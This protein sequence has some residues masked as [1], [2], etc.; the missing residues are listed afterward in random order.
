MLLLTLSVFS[1]PTIFNGIVPPANAVSA[2]FSFAASGD[3]GSLTVSSSVN[4]LNRLMTASPNFFLGLG[5]FSYDPSVTGNTWCG[6]FKSSFNGIQILPGDHDTGGHNSATF[7]E[8]HSYERYVN[9]CP[10]TLGVPLVCG[11]VSGACYGK[12]YYFDYP[13]A[14]P[15]AR[16]IFASPKIYN[17]TGVCTSSPNC[18]SQTGQPCTDQYGCWQYN[19]NDIHYNWTAS[20]IDD[21]RARGIGWVIVATH[22]LCISSADATC[23]TGIA[24]FNMLVQKKVDLIIQAHDNAYERSKQLA[25]NSG[26]CPKIATDGSGY[27]VYNSGCVVDSGL[28]NYTRGLGSVVVV[29]GAWENDLYGVNASASTP[30]NAAEAPFFAEL[31]GKN[32]PGNG[33]GFTKYTA[34]ASRID[35]QTSFSGG[36]SDSF[37]ITNG[38]APIPLS[39]WPAL[40]ANPGT[41]EKEFKFAW[42]RATF[43]AKGLYWAFWVNVGTCEGQSRCLYYSS[44]VDGVTWAAPTN[45]GIHGNRED[46]SVT[47]DGTNVYYARYNETDYFSSTCSRALLFRQ[48]AISGG[49]VNWQ[50]ENVVLPAN[51]TTAF[52]SPNLKIDSNGQAWIGYLYS[53]T[54]TCG[55][56]GTEQPRAIHSKGTNYGSWSSQ[57]V[58]SNAQNGNWAVD[59]ASL[60]K[61]AMYFTYWIASSSTSATDLHGR[62][63]NSTLSADQAISSATDRLDN[64][65]FVFSDGPTVYAVWLDESLQR[66]M[67][68]STSFKA[69]ST[70]TWNKPVKIATSQCCSSSSG[71]GAQPWTA[72]FDPV[73]KSL[74]LYWYNYTNQEVDVYH[75][76]DST[77]AG[78]TLGWT[79]YQATNLSSI[80]SSQ[81]ASA[82]GSDGAEAIGVMFMDGQGIGTAAGNALKYFVYT[83]IAAGHVTVSFTTNPNNP[84]VGQ[85]MTFTATASGATPPYSY[86]WNF[87]DGSTGTGSSTTHTY[88]SP[89][90]F[91][92]VLTVRDSGSPQQTASSQQTISVTGPQPFSASFSFSP[93]SPNAGQ[94][95]TF[96]ASASGGTSPY[97]FLWGFGDGGSA[98][99]SPTTHVYSSSGSY[100]VTLTASDSANH[101][102][103]VSNNIVVS[104]FDFK[105]AANPYLL[106]VQR[107]Q[108]TQS[109]ISVT[110]LGAFVGTVSLTTSASSQ[111]L[112]V[113]MQ[114]PSVTLSAG[115]TLNDNLKVAATKTAPTGV[116]ILT[117]TGTS[118]PLV[119]SLNVTVRVPDFNMTANPSTLSISPGST[120]TSQ[121]LFQSLNGFQ[122]GISTTVSVSPA[123]PK[124][125]LNPN[126][127][128]L[129]VN[130]TKSSVLTIQVPSNQAAGVYNVTIKA[131]SGSLLHLLVV[132]VHVGQHP[133]ATVVSCSSSSVVVNQP[134]TCTATV[135]DTSTIFPITPTGTVTFAETG[136]AG[137][138]SST[139]C[140]LS[141]GI[142]SVTFTPTA[143]G[144]ALVTGT[145]GGDSSHSGSTS[146]AASITVI[147]RTTS[148][149]LVCSTPVVVNQASSCTAS[150]SD[151]SPGTAFTPTGSVT[152]NE[153]GPAG[154]FS[155]AT[156]TLASGSCSVAFT[157]TSTGTAQITG[158]YGG[159]AA[160]STSTSAGA[161]MIINPRATST[162]VVCTS[163][164]VV[165]QASNCTATIADTS[166][167]GSVVTP[168]GNVSFV[169]DSPGTFS[170]TTCTI[171]AVSTG[172]AGCS[173]LYTPGVTGNH[174][175]TG[176]YGGDTVHLVSNGA[177]TIT[178]GQRQTSSAISCSPTGLG[179]NQ[180]CTATVTDN[181]PGTLVTPIGDVSFTTNSTGTFSSNSCTLSGTGTSGVAS[182][183]VTYSPI[184]VATHSITG[185]YSGDTIHLSS[186]GSASIGF[187]KD[188]T[189]TSV[190]CSPSSV[191]INQATTC[192]VTVTDTSSTGP[193]RPT[194]T[195][196]FTSNGAGSFTGS[197][198]TLT[199]QTATSSSCQVNYAPTSGAGTHGITA[200]YNGDAAHSASESST[201]F[202][203]TVTLRT[204]STT[205]SCSPNG[206]VVNQA[207]NCT[208][209]V[210]DSSGSGGVTPTGNVLLTPG[211][212]CALVSGSCSVNITPSS[213]GSLS[214]SASYGGDS[215]HGTSSGST[216][217]LVGK[218]ATSTSDSCSPSPVTNDTVTSC[219][220]TVTDTDIGAAITPNGSVGFAS[221]STGVFSP[222]SC[223]LAATGTVGVAS[224]SVSYTPGVAGLHGITASY[225]GDSSHLGSNGSMTLSVVD[226][227][228][229]PAYALVVSSDGKVSRL[230]QN[231]TLTL[232]GQLVTTALRSVA[233]KPD[234]SYALISGDFAVLLKYDGTT[235]TTIPTGISTG[236]NFWTV[237]WKPDGSYALVGGTSGILFKYDGVKVTT[238]PNT[239]TTILSINWQPSGGYALLVG[240]SGLALTYDGTTVRS[241]AT[242]TTFDL[243][244]AAWN[245]NGAYALIGGLN[246]TLLQFD[247]TTVVAIN[248]SIVPPSNAIRAISFNQAGTMALLAGD[249]GMVLTW[250]GSTLTM[251]TTLA[252]SWLYSISWSPSGTA[253]IVGGSGTVLAYTN[254]TLAKLATSPVTTTQYRG[255]AWKPQ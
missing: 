62:L 246:R 42:E 72:S 175:I 115:Q 250:N 214:V 93:S 204:T 231:G 232:I 244:A 195:V 172:L 157:A 33:L 223:A 106:T 170:T 15:F 30:A 63:Y 54:N 45:V 3:M 130:G 8:T 247:G 237:S 92:V 168:T 58:L 221:N 11:P 149:A 78:P 98:S 230:Y 120:D 6:Q 83:T 209:V 207:T 233:W 192:T 217:V 7:G 162:T 202:S 10:L 208:A 185:T 75:G 9:G 122:G 50:P 119:H 48:G 215:S 166:S 165:N 81:Y 5:D 23:S 56:N 219:V 193:K 55:G 108:N 212:S 163:P 39:P 234:G 187:G 224:C 242:G 179:V 89:G 139:T 16:L 161:S 113:S 88:S 12:E 180:A 2:S 182:C 1:F 82:V 228:P 200:T 77:W 79:T 255:I 194:G 41:G 46:F 114:N 19:A 158:A 132:Q 236:F 31:M 184:S 68:A 94:T 85:Q 188:S 111:G 123:G 57:T 225:A 199:G 116:Y 52:I 189:T 99:G 239:S 69:P 29:Q 176:S 131:T 181:A 241:F 91:T 103:A 136:P 44:S 35:V 138:F 213:S 173:V 118:G 253:Y 142:C 171:A 141:S 238:I 4:S 226:A 22:K 38:S 74:Y 59:L 34:S 198:C 65:A 67:F 64:N 95:I 104:T 47:T 148:T 27:A 146:A 251:L 24:F 210:A 133:S 167:G 196:S 164:V 140:T 160:H 73:S 101:T 37:S 216:T 127:P 60:G 191:A 134:S 125:T 245:P 40:V 145:Y 218:R 229:K 169:S 96:T 97:T 112:T 249:N 21:A 206:V 109:Q 53:A 90:T 147:P 144:N 201:A 153:T 17:M 151:T 252:S 124:A 117:V 156:C 71:Y 28:G 129:T 20:A 235:L 86:S 66:L 126:N 70:E 121:I 222:P 128:S 177:A 110:S 240:K 174:R 14:N 178:V 84:Q 143:T 32:T 107:G 186:Q 211:G 227:A 154:S 87:G 76:L 220:A 190:N 49:S 159:D 105:L 80:T 102:A 155:S 248:T 43:S 100:T 18:S 26:S 243:D 36:F 137:S 25:L 183:Q 135:S 13:A 203:L 150:V 51:A 197:P 205:V 254:G 152:F 61:G